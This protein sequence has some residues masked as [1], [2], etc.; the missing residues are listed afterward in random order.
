VNTPLVSLILIVKDGM[1]HL[2][3]AIE[4]V[5]T[6]MYPHVEL[7]VQDGASTD[8][9]LRYLDSVEGVRMKLVSEPDNG[10]GDAYNRAMARCEGEIIGS[11][12]ADNL[13]EPDGV[14][15]AVASMSADDQ[16]AAVYGAVVLFDSG[17]TERTL[18]PDPFDLL[19][20]VACERVPPFSTAFFARSR[21]GAE[22]YFDAAQ[23]TC[24]DYD[25]WLRLADRPIR[26]I[27]DVVGR[28]RISDKS[29][30]RDPSRYEQ[31]ILDKSR[32]L[33]RY[34]GR[35]DAGPI[36]EAVRSYGK[37]G[38]HLWAAE[39]VYEIE[40]RRSD[41][42]ERYIEIAEIFDPASER[43]SRAKGLPAS[44]AVRADVEPRGTEPA[45]SGSWI[46]KALRAPGERLSMEDQQRSAETTSAE[47]ARAF[48]AGF[49]SEHHPALTRLEPWAGVAEPGWDANFLGVKTRVAYFSMYERLADYSSSRELVTT[50]PVQNE[51][52]FEWIDLLESVFSAD[53][54]FR[55]I[56]LGAGWGKWI[57]SGAVA[58]RRAGLEYFVV[59]VEAEPGHFRWM[60]EHLD[61]NDIDPARARLVQ[62]AVAASEGHAWFHV[63]DPAEWYGQKI[64]DSAPAEPTGSRWFSALSRRF[65][66]KPQRLLTRVPAVTLRSLLEPDEIID[67]IDSDIQ[68]A[69]ADVFE[70]AGERLTEVVRR[71]HIGTHSE[72]NEERLR[73]LFRQLGW[74]SVND[75]RHGRTNETPYGSMPFEDGVQTWTNPLLTGRS[76]RVE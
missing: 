60:K 50:P 6:Q 52:Y 46:R 33:D 24:A 16:V 19:R 36:T 31:F 53:G 7:I 54:C 48:G 56:E 61:D 74:E 29:M 26:A 64:E 40:G 39:S 67:L 59:G 30:T 62:A 71:V 63:G 20:V 68:G 49:A 76:A 51:D 11:I 42:F 8:D 66:K 38:I 18:V 65:A 32:A 55:M 44:S 21:C 43:L 12:D 70:A 47:R 10:V 69:E 72:E 45:P 34:L 27:Q 15:R 73:A 4:S 17:G 41:R 58:A 9:T 75:Y 14:A 25:L 22:L 35:L 37:A 23:Q 28:T 57:A 5:R 2:S 13:L 3:E 1:P